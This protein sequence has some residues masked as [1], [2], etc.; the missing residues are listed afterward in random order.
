MWGKKVDESEVLSIVQV[1]DSVLEH[2]IKP[3]M[4]VRYQFDKLQALNEMCKNDKHGMSAQE[5]TRMRQTCTE[6]VEEL[7]HTTNKPNILAYCAQY[8]SGNFRKIQQAVQLVEMALETKP[9]D[10]YINAKACNIYKKAGEL[11]KA[12]ECAEKAASTNGYGS[13]WQIVELRLAL[14]HK[15]DYEEYFCDIIKKFSEDAHVKCTHK[16]AALFYVAQGDF[17]HALE[18]FKALLDVCDPDDYILG[19]LY[20]GVWNQ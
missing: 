7:V 3:W 15:F 5:R 12:L 20:W 1:I 13:V 2:D 16:N 17:K 9:D 18:H 10:V 6:L 8:I 14:N 4:R 19:E 11:E